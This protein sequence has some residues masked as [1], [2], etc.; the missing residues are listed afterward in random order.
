MKILIKTKKITSKSGT[1]LHWNMPVNNF[2]PFLDHKLL[3]SLKT[4]ASGELAIF[5]CY[6]CQ[7]EIQIF[8]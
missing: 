8:F 5:E 7:A 2:H 4:W 3:M 6:T 1:L